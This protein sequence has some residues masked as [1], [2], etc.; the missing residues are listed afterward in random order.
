MLDHAVWGI[1]DANFNVIL[2]ELIDTSVFRKR[3]IDTHEQE[4]P[5]VMD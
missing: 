5:A 4:L 3:N 1:V 2:P